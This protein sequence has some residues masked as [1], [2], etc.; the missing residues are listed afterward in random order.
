MLMILFEMVKLNYYLV[1]PFQKFYQNLLMPEFIATGFVLT[2]IVLHFFVMSCCFWK[3][4]V[5]LR[6][7]ELFRLLCQLNYSSQ[8]TYCF[9]IQ[10]PLSLRL[11]PLFLQ[12]LSCFQLKCLCLV[13][14]WSRFASAFVTTF[15]FLC[16]FLQVPKQISLPTSLS[17]SMQKIQTE[18]QLKYLVL[19]DHSS[20]LKLK[21]FWLELTDL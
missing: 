17:S 8:A 20:Q 15:Q 7:F 11:A 21:A 4:H 6:Y 19:Q 1:P 13:V 16:F 3:H 18:H 5:A 10:M 14:Y 9:R 12:Q 2:S